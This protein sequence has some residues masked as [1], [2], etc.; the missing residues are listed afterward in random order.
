MSHAKALRKEGEDGGRRAED[1]RQRAEDGGRMEGMGIVAHLKNGLSDKRNDIL[2][3]GY[4]VKGAPGW[5]ILRYSGRPGG[6]V[7]LDGDKFDIGASVYN[8]TGY[9]A[10]ADQRGLIE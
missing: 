2:F 10:H 7:M 1:R 5:D 9:S 3:V 8:L 4:Q 6:Y